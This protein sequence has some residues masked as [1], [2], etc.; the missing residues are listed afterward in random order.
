MTE[1]VDAKV[2]EIL[3]KVKDIDIEQDLKDLLQ[4][5]KAADIVPVE[6]EI[7]VEE[8]VKRYPIT[9]SW[10]IVRCKGCFFF[11]STCFWVVAKPT[12]ANNGQGGALY[13]WLEMY[14]D[15]M[16]NRDD[17][18][19]DEQE[20]RDILCQLTAQVLSLPL[21]I[22]SDLNFCLDVAMFITQKR[23]ERFEE[24]IKQSEQKV[25]L[26][27]QDILDNAEFEAMMLQEK[28]RHEN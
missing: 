28:P 1:R 6:L 8:V 24:I 17:F 14:C 22:F 16:D 27:K 19:A 2:A 15:Y 26:T 4:L 9:D 21:D 7:P 20:Q 5:K 12:L 3:S 13:E 11:H 25:E 10:E 23:T 18:P